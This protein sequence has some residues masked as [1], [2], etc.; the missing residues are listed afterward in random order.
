M[1]QVWC[2]TMTTATRKDGK[3]DGEIKWSLAIHG[4]SEHAPRVAMQEALG[5]PT[6][7]TSTRNTERAVPGRAEEA[8]LPQSLR[9]GVPGGSPCVPPELPRPPARMLLPEAL[10]PWLLEPPGPGEG[11]NLS[12]SSMP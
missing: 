9:G 7:P 8:R 12:R 2:G 4:M 6:G 3:L 1:R 5:L 11:L 10:M